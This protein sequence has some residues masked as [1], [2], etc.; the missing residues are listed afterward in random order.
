MKKIV[1]G[2][3]DPASATIKKYLFYNKFYDRIKFIMQ[4]KNIIYFFYNNLKLYTGVVLYLYQ[5]I[6]VGQCAVLPVLWS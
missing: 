1:R 4:N 5:H 2:V 3:Q 6:I